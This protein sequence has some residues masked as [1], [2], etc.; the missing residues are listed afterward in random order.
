MMV[1][2]L[3]GNTA[4]TTTMLPMIQA[5][6]NAHRLPD[7]TVVADAGMVSAA[8]QKRRSRRPGCRSSSAPVSPH[9]PLGWPSGAKRIPTRRSRWA[10]VRAAVAGG[11][12]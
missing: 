4:E 10:G 2:A 8:N 1:N 12:G 11:N 5:F 9:C 7:V 6:M 3:E